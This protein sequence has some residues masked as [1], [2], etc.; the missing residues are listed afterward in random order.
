MKDLILGLLLLT[1]SVLLADNIGTCP[2]GNLS[3]IVGNTCTTGS[4]VFTFGGTSGYSPSNF[5][6]TPNASGFT[7][8]YL[9]GPISFSAPP[10]FTLSTY[11]SLPFSVSL[12]DST[13]QISSM[14]VSGGS[15]DA[16]GGI[17]SA[18]YYLLTADEAA[19]SLSTIQ[20][21]GTL[22]AGSPGAAYVSVVDIGGFFYQ[23][24]APTYNFP[25]A[26]QSGQFDAIPFYLVANDGASSTWTGPSTTFDFTTGPTQETPEP[27]SLLLFGTGFASLLG[28]L[29]QRVS[30]RFR[31]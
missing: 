11:A 30:H 24:A 27:G 19:S 20:S 26:L 14:S 23:P 1:P 5:E 25:S 8:T 3:N 4:L 29:R 22:P 12:V 2:A 17:S 15:M 21:Y 28:V 6:F 16:Q 7:I 31:S 9:D 18:G 10:N 13:Q